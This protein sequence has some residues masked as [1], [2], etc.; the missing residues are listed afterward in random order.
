MAPKV[1]IFWIS[2][3]VGVCFS[4]LTEVI[5]GARASKATLV[6]QIDSLRSI[7]DAQTLLGV[8]III[9]VLAKIGLFAALSTLG[10][11]WVDRLRAKRKST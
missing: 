6:A 9:M 5:G 8:V 3:G 1:Q 7:G 10:V 11:D 4:I 2:L